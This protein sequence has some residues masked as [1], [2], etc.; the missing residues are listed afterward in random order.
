MAGDLDGVMAALDL[1]RPV[2]VVGH[3]LGA[4]VALTWA[5]RH[6]QD[7]QGVV[8]VDSTPARFVEPAM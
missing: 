1:Q 2:T 7:T 6:L 8:L 3:L 4:A 5:A